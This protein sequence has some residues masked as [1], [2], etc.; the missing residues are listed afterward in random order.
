MPSPNRG[1]FLVL[2]VYG[3]LS[4][5]TNR[6]SSELNRRDLVSKFCTLHVV[7]SFIYRDSKSA[8]SYCN[9]FLQI[10]FTFWS[11][12]SVSHVHR[13]LKKNQV[14]QAELPRCA[15]HVFK[16]TNSLLGRYSY[17]IRPR[18]IAFGITHEGHGSGKSAGDYRFGQQRGKLKANF[19]RWGLSSR[20][21]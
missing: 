16:V 12:S 13:C 11:R 3:V 1:Y 10:A 2:M 19:Y 20:V 14:H 6:W 15:T 21:K 17:D 4:R 18:K 8:F 7:W 5:S 9:V